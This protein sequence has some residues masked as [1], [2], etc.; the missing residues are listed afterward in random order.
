MELS[1]KISRRS[2]RSLEQSSTI[3]KSGESRVAKLVLSEPMV[4]ETYNECPPPGR[5]TVRGMRQT[6]AVDVIKSVLTGSTGVNTVMN[7]VLPGCN[8]GSLLKYT[9]MYLYVPMQAINDF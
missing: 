1:G 3:C 2:G 6:A 8:V 5:F 4:I 9:D 7:P